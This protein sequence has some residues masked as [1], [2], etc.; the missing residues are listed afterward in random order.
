MGMRKLNK[1]NK[2]DEKQ[3]SENGVEQMPLS[4][5]NTLT[6][7]QIIQ[8]QHGFSRRNG[9]DNDTNDNDDDDDR[10]YKNQGID[11]PMKFSIPSVAYE[12]L[13]PKSKRRNL[14]LQLSKRK[15]ENQEKVTA[16]RK[17]VQ[18]IQ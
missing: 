18:N 17:E 1:G 14:T 15:K 7:S 16:R 4:S 11:P 6:D 9:D 12:Q 13:T 2:L 10:D 5:G 3:Q 8:Q